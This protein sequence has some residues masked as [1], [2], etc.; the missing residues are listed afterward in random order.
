MS[1]NSKSIPRLAMALDNYVWDNQGK[2]TPYY[3]FIVEVSAYLYEHSADF[4]IDLFVDDLNSFDDLSTTEFMNRNYLVQYLTED[5]RM[6]VSKES[7][8][9]FVLNGEVA[10]KFVDNN[11]HYLKLTMSPMAGVHYD[12]WLELVGDNR[13]FINEVQ[14]QDRVRIIGELWPINKPYGRA[15]LRVMDLE[16][17][18]VDQESIN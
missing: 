11:D 4:D 8:N 1:I 14:E 2:H 16:K 17:V 6:N 10:N 12:F 18:D 9:V 15:V 5:N 7:A 3:D 13:Y